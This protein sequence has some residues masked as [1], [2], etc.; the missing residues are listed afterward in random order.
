[1]K[2]NDTNIS[3]TAVPAKTD[4]VQS[5]Q[6]STRSDGKSKAAGAS[7]DRVVISDL[8]GNLAA[9]LAAP[10]GPRAAYVNRIAETVRSGNYQIDSK[11]ISRSL[12]DEALSRSGGR[13]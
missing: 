3:G 9:A 10:D 1:M 4:A 7:G 13:Q 5:A 12:V 11:A 2:I 8:T 6:Q